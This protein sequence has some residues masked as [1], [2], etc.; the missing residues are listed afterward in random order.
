MNQLSFTTKN[1]SVKNNN[2]KC[3]PL[4]K[5]EKEEESDSEEEVF[6]GKKADIPSFTIAVLFEQRMR[7]I[8]ITKSTT[9]INTE[10][11][12]TNTSNGQNTPSSNTSSNNTSNNT[13]NS[14][15]SFWLCYRLNNMFFFS[16][17]NLFIYCFINRLFY[18]SCFWLN[19]CLS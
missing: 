16:L 13:S 4:N 17:P 7:N 15:T 18:S 10:T 5:L 2:Q 11:S 19:Y 3:K 1:Y 8:P 14:T 9:P 6:T 12:Q